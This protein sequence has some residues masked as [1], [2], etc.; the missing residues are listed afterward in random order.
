MTYKKNLKASRNRR[1]AHK[2]FKYG[3]ESLITELQILEEKTES[4]P[5]CVGRGRH[6]SPV[7]RRNE[8]NTIRKLT[9]KILLLSTVLRIIIL[10]KVN[11]C[12]KNKNT[13]KSNS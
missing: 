4:T 7:D 6:N 8:Q 12:K 3:G 9:R 5:D 11:N 10:Q 2:Q 13:N 1:Y